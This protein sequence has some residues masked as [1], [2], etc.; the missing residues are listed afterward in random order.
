VSGRAIGVLI[1]IAVVLLVSCCVMLGVLFD[2][3]RGEVIISGDESSIG[4]TVMVDGVAI[5]T[6]QREI[7]RKTVTV[8]EGEH[9]V[10]G[11]LRGGDTLYRAGQAGGWAVVTVAPRKQAQIFFV[12]KGD[13]LGAILPPGETR[14]CFVSVA[15]HKV[16]CF[17]SSSD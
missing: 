8:P 16:V 7:E 4:M 5:A 11:D 10:F 13:T 12:G 17:D 1:G 2:D 9:G 6:L 14:V 3:E 15:R